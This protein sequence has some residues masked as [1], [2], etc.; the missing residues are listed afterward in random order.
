MN[1]ICYPDKDQ[2]PK[3]MKRPVVKQDELYSLVNQIFSEI[4]KKGRSGI[5]K[6]QQDL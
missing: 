3:L 2:W 5:K 1:K 4:K 6:I